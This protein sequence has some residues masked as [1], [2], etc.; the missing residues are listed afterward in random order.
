MSRYQTSEAL[1]QRAKQSLA[2]GVSSNVRATA[3]PP[4]YYQGA[5]GS[6][7]VDADGNNYLDYTLAQGPMLLG[8]SPSVVLDF[9]GEAMQ[10]GQLYAGQHELEITLSEKLQQL[11]PCAELVRFGNSGSEVVHAA[12]RLARAHTGRDKILKF[13]GQ[14]HGWYDD[15]LISVHPPLELAGSHN[16]PNTVPATAGQSKHVLKSTLVTRWNDLELLRS[17][18]Q[19]HGDELAA[20]IM[21]PVMSNTSCI[22]PQPGYLEGVRELCSDQGIV[23]IFDEVITGFRLALGGAQAY[24]DVTPDLA[25]FAK[26]MANGFPI[27]CLAGKRDIMERIASLEVNHS[28]TYNTN[29]MAT[30]AAWATVNELERIA[31]TGYPRLYELGELLRNGLREIA[32][33]F[34]LDVLIQGIGPVTHMSF[35]DQSEIVDYR[36][37]L[38]TDTALYQ[39]F[40]AAMLDQN[41][42][43]LSRGLWYISMAHTS[44]DIVETLET[45]E[46]VLVELAENEPLSD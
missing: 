35:T 8:H 9:V 4:L 16:H 13:E 33:K 38:N 2:G 37:W 43:L 14:Y 5:K 15:E 45:V 27:S 29:V 25:T 39:Q 31:E 21:E 3:K 1:W 32:D 36:S 28:G 41:I 11:I 40:V 6:R 26:A 22:T 24:F 42:R 18:I 44:D 12:L 46:Q 23:L 30:A 20:V 34:G 7:I 10:N 17:V 19:Q